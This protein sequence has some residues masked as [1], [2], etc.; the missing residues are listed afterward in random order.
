MSW[1]TV[2]VAARLVEVEMIGS[3]SV[4]ATLVAAGLSKL[5]VVPI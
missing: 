1:A 3:V 4:V 5:F 2:A